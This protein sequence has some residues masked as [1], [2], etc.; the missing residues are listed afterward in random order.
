M[1]IWKDHLRLALALTG[2]VLLYFLLRIGFWFFNISYFSD[3]GTAD[4]WSVFFSG[5][6]FDLSAIF[7]LNAIVI[8]AYF[9]PIPWVHHKAYVVLLK[10]LFA[11][12]NSV[13]VFF[14]IIDF[15]YFGFIQARTTAEIFSYTTLSSDL[16]Y[17]IMPFVRDFWYVL[18]LTAGFVFL[19]YKA[20]GLVFRRELKPAYGAGFYIYRSLFLILWAGLT[21]VMMRGGFQLRPINIATAAQYA[22]ARHIPLVI[23]TPFSIIRT[24]NKDVIKVSKYFSD[25]EEAEKIYKP[26]HNFACDTVA[27][28][29]KNVVVIILESFS[30]EYI[31]SLNKHIDSG[32]YAGYTPFLDSIIAQSLVFEDA[33][34][35]GRRSIDATLSILS[36]IPNLMETAFVLSGYA[37]HQI[38]SIAS[39]LSVKGYT[40]YFFHGGTNGT[41]GFDNFA[42]LTGFDHYY[43]RTEYGNDAHFDGHWG[44]FDEPFLQ[45]MA[46]E[47]N[48]APAPFF[49]LL[50]TLSSH[51]PYTIPEAYQNRFPKGT[52]PIHESIGYADYALKRFFETA[53]RMPWFDNT[54][55][56]ITADHA[57][58]SY[59]RDYQT[60]SGIFAVPLLFYEPKNPIYKRS[61]QTAQ[62]TDILPTLMHRMHYPH[63]FVAFGRSL[64]DTL[65]TGLSVNFVNGMYQI[66][67][68]PYLITFDGSHMIALYDT[69]QDP[70]QKHNVLDTFDKTRKESLTMLIK[71]YIQSYQ[72]RMHYNKLTDCL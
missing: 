69:S 29:E 35:N 61:Q 39:L 19:I 31:G 40:S 10:I 66:V 26:V 25:L 32:N 51:H 9:L 62:H 57:A 4:L 8:F 71:A 52:L 1:H 50:F 42:H 21:I 58:A 13:A 33:Y 56:V 63:C 44:I 60:Q 12:I 30:K 65:Q 17:L 27:F 28:Q 38:H 46:H 2:L 20:S 23:N 5:I 67:K 72:Y 22:T 36:G 18:L 43:G 24:F 64:L 7:T 3:M 49:S 70:L 14:A 16:L 53:S 48:K 34:A 45:R 41:M 47:L 68:A 54:I 11:T 37:S 6:R 55:F 59:Y 15:A